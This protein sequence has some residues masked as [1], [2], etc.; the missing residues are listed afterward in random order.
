[1]TMISAIR[2]IVGIGYDLIDKIFPDP[3]KQSEAKRLLLEAE[4]AGELNFIEK[5]MAAIIAE[6]NSSDSFVSRAR[7]AFLYV[8]YIMILSAIP[9]GILYA[10]NPHM[11]HLIGEGLKEW[12]AAIP[13]PLWNFME[14]GYSGYVVGRTIDKCKMR[15]S[16]DK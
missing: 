1:M 6:A 3:K 4:Q 10:F 16:K 2:D 9:M 15:L 8:M 7:P 13:K 5:R 12:L 11:A 14:L